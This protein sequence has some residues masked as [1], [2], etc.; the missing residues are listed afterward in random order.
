MVKTT[1]DRSGRVRI[2]KDLRSDVGLEPGDELGLEPIEGGFRLTLLREGGPLSRKGRVL[3]FTGKRAGD[4]EGTVDEVQE[5]RL[6]SLAK[7]GR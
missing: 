4:I 5:E 6:R 7:L 1:I 3:V 2:P